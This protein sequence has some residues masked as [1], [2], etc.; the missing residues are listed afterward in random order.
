MFS[1]SAA[2]ETVTSRG[3]CLC[4]IAELNSD[5]DRVK[6][7]QQRL[8]GELDFIQAQQRE[9]EEMLVPLEQSVEQMPPISFQQHADLER[10]HT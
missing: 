10:E 4:Q 2:F 9:L 6:L 1:P 8:E 7:D 5:V 3:V